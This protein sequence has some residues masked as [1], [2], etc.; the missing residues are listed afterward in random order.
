MMGGWLTFGQML[1]R[2]QIGQKAVPDDTAY[3]TVIRTHMGLRV[4][5]RHTGEPWK[6]FVP[7]TYSNFKLKYRLINIAQEAEHDGL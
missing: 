5:D 1:D 2:I 3:A 4:V 7:I 6:G